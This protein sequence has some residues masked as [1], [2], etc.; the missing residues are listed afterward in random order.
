MTRGAL[1]AGARRR[2]FAAATALGLARLGFFTPHRHAASARPAGYPGLEPR[3]RAAEPAMRDLL[4][5]IDGYRG[6]LLALDAAAPAPAPA[7]RFGQ[8][9]FARLDAAALYAMVRMRAP[10]C[11]VEVGSGHSTRFMARAVADGALATTIQ[12]IDPAPR[13]GL[14]D[15][16]VRHVP[17][18]L[19]DLAPGEVLALRPGDILF[20][21]SS[22]V[23]MPG[24]DVDRL[25]GDILPRLAP[26]VVVHV[27]DI[28]LPDAYPEDWHWRGYNEQ[29]L[30][31]CLI[32]GGYRLIWS[33]HWVASR[34]RDWLAGTVIDGLPLVAGTPETSVWL[35][36]R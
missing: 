30:I 14:A 10:E 15:L 23:A 16:G 28:V 34:H 20:I 12:C 25:F 17:R 18:L 13:A 29:L 21:D 31:A 11:I 32:E 27:H 7:P 19:Q 9:W 24:T 33:S 22:H 6:E 1:R 4:A 5:G 3:F 35:E 2:A 36:K 26:G 8:S